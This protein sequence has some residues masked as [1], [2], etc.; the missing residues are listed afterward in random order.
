MDS[1]TPVFT[2]RQP[3][4]KAAKD[5]KEEKHGGENISPFPLLPFASFAAFA[6]GFF[7]SSRGRCTRKPQPVFTFAI[8]L[9]YF[10]TMLHPC[11]PP[12][13]FLLLTAACLLL[14]LAVAGCGRRGREA[15]KDKIKQAHHAFTPDD[16]VKAAGDGDRPLV[17]AFLQGGIDH[18][19]ADSRGL[20]AVMAAAA[21]GKIDVLKALLDDN[22]KPDLATKDGKTALHLAAEGN[23]P[24]AVRTLIEAN[25][26]VRARDHDGFAPLLRA[27]QAGNERVV[28]VFLATSRDQLARDGQLDRG[29]AV[30]AVLGKTKI[31][32]QFLDKGA[33]VNA[34]VENRQTAL[35]LAAQYG[36]LETV[37]FLLSRGAD[38]RLT[39]KDG[40][41]ASVIALQKGYPDI[42]RTL[43]AHTPGGKPAAVAAGTPTPTPSPTPTAPPQ[44]AAASPTP[45]LT[46][47]EAREQTWLKEKGVTPGD[48]LKRDTGQD[49]DH[50][51]F[52]NDEELAA[53]TDP[54]DPKSHP[55]YYTKLRLRRIDGETFPIVFES[56]TNKGAKATLSIHEK[57]GGD[58]ARRVEVE[59]G[60]KIPGT[61]YRVER[62]RARNIA[63][64]DTGRPVD[65]SELT[66]V[67]TETKRKIVLVKGMVSNSADAR[68]VLRFEIDGSEKTVAQ[69]EMFALPIEPAT[70]FQV[71]DVRPTQVILKIVGTEQT[72]TVEK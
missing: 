5:A 26:D 72:V 29:L 25:A 7:D 15:A 9:V 55:P 54:N 71:I 61:P 12:R 47:E 46:P 36:Q 34:T 40:A 63:E 22:A 52:T 2:R 66:L 67:D 24:D 4:A 13:F 70:R 69:G 53:G 57:G 19:A 39:D 50:D 33:S 16:F 58:T 8:S 28:E 62:V 30:A 59:V 64:K 17:E 45:P 21:A 51:G 10:G 32:G 49:D 31:V 6:R 38:P 18:N 44:L 3:L 48:V 65:V 43:D 68:A 27:V 42:A 23:Q 1:V 41:N 20:T 37:E 60:S 11:R 35:M 14:T 56:T